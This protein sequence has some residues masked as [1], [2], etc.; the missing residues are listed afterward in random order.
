MVHNIT[1]EISEFVATVK[2]LIADGRT[3]EQVT[4]QFAPSLHPEDWQ[5]IHSRLTSEA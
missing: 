5:A 2:D 3:F 4:E 1:T